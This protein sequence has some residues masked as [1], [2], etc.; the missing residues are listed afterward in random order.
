MYTTVSSTNGNFVSLG[1]I[2]KFKTLVCP[3]S[4]NNCTA[5]NVFLGK[6]L[7]ERQNINMG[8]VL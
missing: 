5:I 7:T 1:N 6:H 4:A 3:T 8:I 2:D